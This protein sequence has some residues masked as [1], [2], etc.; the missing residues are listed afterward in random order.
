MTFPGE[1]FDRFVF[2]SVFLHGALFAFVILSP[3]LFP[4]FGPN[5]GSVTG[6]SGGIKV[7]VVG[8]VS[9]VPL[10]T[11]EV[12]QENAPANESPGFYQSE[13]APPPPPPDKTAELI[14]DKA[15]KVKPTP[16]APSKP[17]A[18]KSAPAAE[19]PPLNAIPYGQ[20]G[21]PSMN[22]GAFSTGAG[23]AGAVFGDGAFGDRYGTYV[24]AM[25]RRISQ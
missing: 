22:Y 2:A 18:P 21:R 12:V 11:P 23:Q 1:R 4:S 10:P 7:N 14:P 9:G 19:P 6:G 16:K 5:W 17:P 3:K 20:G 15:A 13:P 24:E 8:N 25:Q